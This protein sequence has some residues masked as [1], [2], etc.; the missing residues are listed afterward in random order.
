MISSN[1]T[2]RSFRAAA[3]EVAAKAKKLKGLLGPNLRMAGEEIMTD[4]KASRPGHGVPRKDGALANSGRV[5]GPFGTE[6]HPSVELSFGGASAPYALIQH[7]VLKFKHRLGEAR[8]LIR[9]LERWRPSG[10]SA[11]AALR[12]QAIAA[13]REK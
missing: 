5:E 2:V 3:R 8:Y 4:V 10:S 7:E 1:N 9:G 12:A 13:L 11:M 6:A